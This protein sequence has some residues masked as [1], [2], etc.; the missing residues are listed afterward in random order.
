[1]VLF[2]LVAQLLAGAKHAGPPHAAQRAPQ[3]LRARRSRRAHVEA[4]A[5]RRPR[6]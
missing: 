2:L 1:M 4:L 6:G 3:Q 5:G